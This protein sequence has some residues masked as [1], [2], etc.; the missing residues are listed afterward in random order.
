MEYASYLAGLRWSDHP[1]CTH[2]TLAA[3]A[4]LV[5]DLSSDNARSKLALHVSSVIGLTGSDPRVPVLLSSLAASSALPIASQTRQR[6]LATGLVRCELLLAAWEGPEIERARMRIRVAFLMA[7]G[8]EKWA[9]DFMA[10]TPLHKMSSISVSEE[11]ILRTSV[12]GIADACVPDSDQRLATLLAQA[13]EECA[14]V[15]APAALET[16]EERVLTSA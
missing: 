6:A 16:T 15:L 1:S 14:G 13:I 8:T 11:A 3:L 4:R 9:R 2:P 10:G 5:N 7:P 12:I